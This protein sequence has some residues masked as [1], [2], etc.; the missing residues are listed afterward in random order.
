V[1]KHTELSMQMS[2]TRPGQLFD[3]VRYSVVPN[4][5]Y[6]ILLAGEADLICVSKA[7]VFHEVEIKVS[8][9]DLKRDALKRHGHED[10]LISFTWFAVPQE[11]ET[12]AETS[13]PTRYGIVSVRTVVDSRGERTV[14]HV[15]RKPKRNPSCTK[16]P[17][18]EIINK[19]LRLGVIRMWSRGV[20]QESLLGQIRELATENHRLQDALKEQGKVVAA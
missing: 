7:G 8:V 19:L 10:R 15:V 20:T 18:V 14:T 5:S 1:T 11:L 2:L 4:V 16:K 12:V 13:L 17:T 3:F 9:S 6:G